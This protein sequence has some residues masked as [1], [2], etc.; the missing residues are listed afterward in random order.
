[1]IVSKRFI[2]NGWLIG[3]PLVAILLH[4]KD[5]GN[6]FFQDDFFHLLISRVENLGDF[7]GFFKFRHDSIAYRPLTIQIYF[8]TTRFFFGLSPL[9]FRF[10]N[11]ILL[12]CSFYLIVKILKR[13]SSRE[14]GLIAASIWI[15]S[16]IHFMSI[17]WISA[18][19]QIIGTF[20]YLLTC[21][22]FIT[23]IGSKNAAHYILAVLS[24]ILTL[25]SFEF[26][27]TLPIVLYA[28]LAL[29][30][31]NKLKVQ[32]KILIPFLLVDVIYITLRFFFKSDPQI[33]DYNLKVNIDSLK[34]LFWYV[35]WALNMPEEFKYQV[36][37]KLII[38]NSRY[39]SFFP[40]FIVSSYIR[41]I[42][43]LITGIILPVLLIYKIRS[44][45]IWPIVKYLLLWFVITIIPALLIPNHTFL[46]YL[47]LPSI[48][49]YALIATLLY[50]SQRKA[51]LILF[52]SVWLYSSFATVNFYGKTSYMI[53]AQQVS[54]K[55]IQNVTSQLPALPKN[56]SVLYS[57]RN[58]AHIQAL[59]DQNALRAVYNDET[60]R[61]YWNEQTFLRDLQTNITHGPVYIINP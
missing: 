49:L 51:L 30:K 54:R 18:A 31:R 6:Y 37:D 35:L 55:F 19:Y 12:F 57:V 25:G 39:F 60:V 52:F 1:M 58:P 28:Y 10:I 32:T 2:N 41:L 9:I 5:F 36:V 42:L 43:I 59:S 17:T 47:T 4:F 23:F 50:A 22:F 27:T 38:I 26:A 46:M 15:T 29:L 14:I 20:F 8:S 45:K 40:I 21:H 56:S 24:F 34:A 13:I 16:S 33:I 61:T 48:G 7:I 53:E 44:T 11:V 3:A